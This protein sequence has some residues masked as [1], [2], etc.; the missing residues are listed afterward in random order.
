MEKRL[1]F[2][3]A[4][5]VPV[6][7]GYMTLGVAYG[8]VMQRAGYDWRWTLAASAFVYAGSF[9]FAL[10]GMLGSPVDLISVALMTLS[11]NSRHIFYGL[12]LIDRFAGLGKFKPYMIFALSDETYSLLC[13]TR[14]PPELDEN[15]TAF[16]MAALDQLY[17]VLGSALGALLG[18]W[19]PFDLTGIDFAMTALFVVIFLDQWKAAQSRA[20][21]LIGLGCGLLC[22]IFLGP[23]RFLLPALLLAV[24]LLLLW[25]RAAGKEA[26]S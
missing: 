20:P 13:G 2:A 25:R 9:Q 14:I 16:A 22:L 17:W 10:A 19:L 6:F 11:V 7:L 21:A 4:R 1:R 3:L 15:R 18:E 26:V 8:L 12:S 23:A 24:A 5:T